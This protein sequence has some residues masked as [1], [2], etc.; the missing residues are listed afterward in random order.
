MRCS[1]F[2]VIMGEYAVEAAARELASLGYDGVE[3]RVHPDYHI[4][5]VELED[6]A[7]ELVKLSTDHGLGIPVLG[8]YVRVDALKQLESACRAAAAMGCPNVRISLR[9]VYDGR[10]PFSELFEEARTDL[11]SAAQT[12]EQHNVRGLFETHHGTIAES[13]SGMRQL[14]DGFPP[15]TFGT[16]FD[17]G[18]MI[19]AG[20]ESWRMA[21]DI[22]GPYLVHVHVKNVS[23]N[24]AEDVSW[25]WAFDTLQAGMVDWREVIAALGEAG[26]DGYLSVEDLYGVKLKTTGFVGESLPSHA[27]SSISIKQKLADDLAFLK[28]CLP[29]KS[30]S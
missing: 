23:W 7:A 9:Q 30:S 5:P 28:S 2:T 25:R 26:Y 10:Q 15:E 22:L 14:L 6:K 8:T 17:P 18:N 27:I 12:L 19:I 3:W 11:A 20:C 13:A 29:E 21:I 1:V 24:R 4:H 16:I